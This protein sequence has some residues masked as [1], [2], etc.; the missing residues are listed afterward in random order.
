MAD[1]HSTAI[2]HDGAKIADDVVIGPYCVIGA[3]VE[4][5]S[6]VKLIS[7]VVVDGDT[8]IGENTEISPFAAIGGKNQDL[9]DKEKK[10]KLIIGKNNSIREYATIQPG[11][12]DGIGKT[13]VGDNNLLMIGVHIAHDCILG[14]NCIM[15]NNATLAGHVTVGDCAIIGGFAAVHQF[16]RIGSFV[17]IGGM[18]GVQRDVIPYA[19]L[20]MGDMKGINL[21][22]L[23]RRGYPLS[24]IADLR[25]AVTELFAP[26]GTLAERVKTVGEKYADSAPVQEIVSF[27]QAESKRGFCQPKQEDFRA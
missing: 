1:I 3:N 14:S 19:L 17:M 8:E 25:R 4:L 20:E 5:K 15:S 10:G 11:S 12:P 27:M 22:G 2:I 21:V 24:D 6:G 13:V 7:H 23:K 26:D 16:T 9:K 18:S